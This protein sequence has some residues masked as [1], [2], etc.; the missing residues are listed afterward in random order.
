MKLLSK[1]VDVKNK[2]KQICKY[3]LLRLK[4]DFSHVIFG[5]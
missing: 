2:C 1:E 4:Q 3:A 5:I